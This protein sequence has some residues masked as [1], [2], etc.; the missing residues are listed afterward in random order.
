M[1]VN[2]VLHLHKSIF[3]AYSVLCNW[4]FINFYLLKNTLYSTKNIDLVVIG[5]TANLLSQFIEMG[6]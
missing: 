2:F 4:I 1:H 5:K 3:I 6:M